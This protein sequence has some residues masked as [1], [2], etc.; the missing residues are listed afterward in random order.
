MDS[1]T[2]YECIWGEAMFTLYHHNDLDVCQHGDHERKDQDV[3]CPIHSSICSKH[4][5]VI[6]HTFHSY[7]CQICDKFDCFDGFVFCDKC[8]GATC[9]DC[10]INRCVSCNTPS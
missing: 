10:N 3:V 5:E 2:C 4:H 6:C 9:I 7:I 1:L 8:G